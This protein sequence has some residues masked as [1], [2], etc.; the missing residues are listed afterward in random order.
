MCAAVIECARAGGTH[1]DAVI[2]GSTAVTAEMLLPGVSSMLRGVS[3]EAVFDDGLRLV[4]LP[5]FASEEF[6]PGEVVRRQPVAAITPTAF[7]EIT[8]TSSID[9]SLTSHIHVFETNPMLLMDR[10]VAYG[11]RPAIPSAHHIGIAPGE[12]VVVPLI[13]ISGERVVM[14]FAGFVD[15]PLDAPHAK[16]NALNKLRAC[17]YLDSGVDN[18]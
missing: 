12:T 9:I 18:V 6:V 13:E 7:V 11:M 17:G 16:Q 10:S 5:D 2:A 14:G 8:N 3:V 15:G 1:A 4:A